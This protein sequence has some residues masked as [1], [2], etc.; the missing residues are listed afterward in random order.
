LKLPRFSPDE[1]LGKTFVRTLDDGQ[2]YR[3]TVVRNIQDH[4]AENHD[5]N[6]F[7]VELGDGAFDE[8]IA[9]GTLCECIEDLEDEDISSE[10]KAWTFTD[11][12]GHQGRLRKSRKDWKRS[13]YNVLLLWD[14][15]SETYEPLEM[16]IKDDTVTLASYDLK[17]DLL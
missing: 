7:L 2:S 4:D 5:N 3:A 16:V 8:I 1:L 9:Y 10:H 14:D 11:V 12:I 13:L 6:K 15:G 17:H